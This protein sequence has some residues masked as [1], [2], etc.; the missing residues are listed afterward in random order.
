MKKVRSSTFILRSFGF[1]QVI[2]L[3]LF[4]LLFSQKNFA[5]HVLPMNDETTARWLNLQGHSAVQPYL[6]LD[7]KADYLASG[8]RMAGH[9]PSVEDRTHTGYFLPRYTWN[10]VYAKPFYSDKQSGNGTAI[11][12]PDPVYAFAKPIAFVARPVYDFQFGKEFVGNRTMF[13]TAGGIILNADYKQKFGIELRFATGITGLTN[14]QDSLS[15]AFGMLPGWGDRA[16]PVD[17]NGRYSFQ[18]FSGNMIWRPSKVFNLQVGRDKHFWGDGYRSLF[19]SDLGPAFPYIK[20]QTTIWKLQYTSLFAWL[21][22][23]TNSTGSAKDFRSKF[24]TFHYLSFNAAKWLN[25]GVFESVIWQGAD[26]NRYRGFDPNY[27][28]PIVFFR[29]VEYSAG[30]SDN[31]MLGFA[32][33][34]RFNANNQFYS[35]L[36][37][38]EF[39][40]K[41]I[42]NW[43]AGWWANKQGIQMGYKCSNFGTAKNL[44]M[45]VEM[46]IVRP[47]TYSHGSPQQSYTHAAAPL[48]H[49]LGANFFE[50]FGMLSYQWKGI[51]VTGKLVGIRY[52]MDPDGKNFGQNI[53]LSYI[54]RSATNPQ[55]PNEHDY[56]HRMFDGFGTN[57]L[58]AEFKASYTFNTAFPLRLEFTTGARSQNGLLIHQNSSYVTFGLSLPLWKSYRD[59]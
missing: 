9:L 26:A 19:L 8:Q 57:I 23:W 17:T 51:T 3:L 53:F 27:L 29:P 46:N 35:Q 58:Y 31:V 44:F 41:E 14:N 5:Q 28:N 32:F 39:F 45:Q 42:K 7:V 47:Y 16:Y 48:A 15:R 20:Q 40:L 36:I 37:L 38:D 25:I 1:L 13:T 11:L 12:P 21:Q 59:Y 55:T 10:S 33:K 2:F 50:L 52:G 34:I 49:P 18:H 54:D 30:S 24:A 4:F 43:K 56:G 6:N 22:D